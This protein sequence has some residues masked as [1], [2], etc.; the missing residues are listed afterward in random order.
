MPLRIC[1]RARVPGN[2]LAEHP[3]SLAHGGSL[4]VARAEIKAN[5]ASVQMSSQGRCNFM[6]RRQL[7]RRDRHDCKRTLVNLLSHDRG[8]ECSRWRFAIISLK[9]GAE[10]GRSREMNPIPSPGPE[11]KF[12]EPLREKEIV[13]RLRMIF[14]KQ[15]GGKARDRTIGPFQGH[16]ERNSIARCPHGCAKCAIGQHGGT[17]KPPQN[18]ANP[19]GRENGAQMGYLIKPVP[20]EYPAGPDNA[21]HRPLCTRRNERCWQPAQRRLFHQSGPR[22]YA[23]GSPPPRWPQRALPPPH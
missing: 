23:R 15:V 21:S 6:S 1:L 4:S 13:R 19:R 2:F 5:A 8:I 20:L 14:R 11:E 3:L 17:I 16:L 10:F 18:P 22:P 12:Q 7:L 9:L